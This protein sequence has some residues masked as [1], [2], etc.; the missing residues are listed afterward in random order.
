MQVLILRHGED[1]IVL[2]TFRASWSTSTRVPG[3]SS[4]AQVS[5][6]PTAMP[7]WALP[8][9][10]DWLMIEAVGS[11]KFFGRVSRVS[12]GAGASESGA[13]AEPVQ[14]F[15]VGFL[16]VDLDV[17]TSG[18][19]RERAGTLYPRDQWLR[20]A[21]LPLM[22]SVTS[23]I[24]STLGPFASA[25][26][27]VR[28]PG[29]AFGPTSRT[30]DVYLGDV[31]GTAYSDATAEGLGMTGPNEPVQ[32]FSPH[33][34]RSSLRANGKASEIL[35]STYAPS[36]DL[37]E[38]FPALVPWRPEVAAGTRASAAPPKGVRLLRGHTAMVLRY[39][40]APF[41]PA[42]VRDRLRAN[43]GPNISAPF[44]GPEEAGRFDTK[45]FDR[46]T[47]RELPET[48]IPFGEIENVGAITDG[49][50]DVTAVSAWL[51]MLPP[52]DDLRVSEALGLPVL[53]AERSDRDGF[54]LRN[55]LWP[56]MPPAGR[57]ADDAAS[58]D[59]L[60][61]GLAAT[62]YAFFAP[63]AAFQSGT[64]RIGRLR[65]DISP[66]TRVAFVLGAWKLEAYVVEVAHEVVADGIG[67]LSG[68]TTVTFER[69]LWDA[70]ARNPEIWLYPPKV[71]SEVAQSQATTACDDPFEACESGRPYLGQV[72][73]TASI[74]SSTQVFPDWSDRRLR[75]QYEKRS[76]LWLRKWFVCRCESAA[77]RN[78]D[79]IFDGGRDVGVEADGFGAGLPSDNLF[80]AAACAYVIERYWQTVY[81]DAR[82]SV[83]CVWRRNDGTHAVGAAI[84]FAVRYRDGAGR[85]QWV[86]AVR[87]W[88]GLCFLG[89][90]ARIPY[91]GAG[92][93]LNVNP[94]TGLRG[95]TPG[96]AG[97]PSKGKR[98]P[99][100]S[101]DTHYDFRGAFGVRAGSGSTAAR[102]TTWIWTDWTGDGRDELALGAAYKP[103]TGAVLDTSTTQPEVDTA[104]SFYTLAQ[105]SGAATTEDAVTRRKGPI[106][107]TI[108]GVLANIADT[109]GYGGS[110]TPTGA[111]YLDRMLG[112]TIE[113]GNGPTLA[114]QLGVTIANPF[115]SQTVIPFAE[116]IIV[117]MMRKRRRSPGWEAR[118]VDRAGLRDAVGRVFA[119]ITARDSTAFRRYLGE[120]PLEWEDRIGRRVPNVMQVLGLDP[121]CAP[122]ETPDTETRTALPGETGAPDPADT[123]GEP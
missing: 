115:E 1:P 122:A 82:V 78:L 19:R 53:D 83:S 74:T 97:A 100:G 106:Q 88:A 3:Q 95:L 51:S 37:I 13:R 86:D 11:V 120:H 99:G 2:T 65:L 107:D 79:A 47:W 103:R 68:R 119:E 112:P 42:P 109:V 48:V 104:P 98:P 89:A 55:L 62:A 56:F 26:Y 38:L 70:E 108:T 71:E 57:T 85:E 87:A 91:G 80:V 40:M 92:L 39:R 72:T 25:L 52:S 43:L 17:A 96:E 10:R 94:E 93:Y 5:L 7:P 30:E 18:A 58:I 31:I 61:F 45:Q 35:T 110:L 8:T 76:L 118:E 16:D 75:L 123:G 29:S 54:R 84:D 114:S 22:E 101:S 64:A 105:G 44:V 12:W 90:R 23:Q 49:S 59:A 50:R 102:P 34:I 63:G 111:R 27:P 36:L 81:P 21:A 66:G 121:W 6:D 73:D 32:G 41:R 33:G 24:G 20:V 69:G 4:S 67:T 15:A 60:V 117:D 9:P 28:V 46:P 77:R 14:V 113:S 116:S